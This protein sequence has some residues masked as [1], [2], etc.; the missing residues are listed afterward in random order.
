MAEDDIY[1]SKRKYEYFVQ[2]LEGWILP[3][4]FHD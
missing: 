1:N 2:N 3:G 4:G